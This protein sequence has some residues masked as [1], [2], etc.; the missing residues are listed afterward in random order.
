MKSRAGVVERTEDPRSQGGDELGDSVGGGVVEEGLEVGG[1]AG[2]EGLAGLVGDPGG[3]GGD[4]EAPG[5]KKGGSKE[6]VVGGGWFLGEDVESGSGD[7]VG[8]NGVG[9]GRFIHEGAAAGVDEDGALLHQDEG[10]GVDEV[11]GLR[12][13]GAVEGDD[14][15]GG[16][17]G[18]SIDTRGV[19]LGGVA[20][21]FAGEGLDV[22]AEGLGDVSDG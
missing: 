14:V 6:R 19:G 18:V 2:E 5:R 10:V 17:E 4:E 21:A 7:G 15:G 11:F 12:G 9:E 20:G 1:D 16:E 8:A 3:V 22:H 13:E